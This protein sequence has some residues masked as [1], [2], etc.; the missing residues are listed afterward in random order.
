MVTAK[1]KKKNQN[2]LRIASVKEVFPSCLLLWVLLPY[3]W[4]AVRRL[5]LTLHQNLKEFSGRYIGSIFG[6]VYDAEK[7]KC[8]SS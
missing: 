8:R 1:K 6:D 2:K 3:P 7:K 4:K 5:P